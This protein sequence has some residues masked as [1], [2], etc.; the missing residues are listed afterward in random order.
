MARVRI[1]SNSIRKFQ[2]RD[3]AWRDEEDTPERRMESSSRDRSAWD[4]RVVE[5]VLVLVGGKQ[6]VFDATW[7]PR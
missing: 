6:V 2:S 7:S 5:E 4:T 3:A 1:V